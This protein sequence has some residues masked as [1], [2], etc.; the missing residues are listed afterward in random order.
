MG[1]GILTAE[2]THLYS[3]AIVSLNFYHLCEGADVSF[4]VSDRYLCT[5]FSSSRGSQPTSALR[6]IIMLKPWTGDLALPCLKETEGSSKC[7][8]DKG[9]KKA[10]VYGNTRWC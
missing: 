7:G 3:I 2:S 1:L 8:K 5:A 6:D 9:K 4:R 10:T